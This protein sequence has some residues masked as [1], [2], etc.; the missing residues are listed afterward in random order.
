[1]AVLL[2]LLLLVLGE[3]DPV[4]VDRDPGAEAIDNRTKDN[5]VGA[6]TWP[7]FVIEQLPPTATKQ[8][9][10]LAAKRQSYAHWWQLLVAVR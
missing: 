3:G 4:A 10:V 5:R 7:A 1:L 6:D 9:N 8:A 2:L